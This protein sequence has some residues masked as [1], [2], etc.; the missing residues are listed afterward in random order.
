MTNLQ[1]RYDDEL[2]R[3]YCTRRNCNFSCEVASL[4]DG[5]AD[6]ILKYSFMKE[7]E[8]AFM[9][10]DTISNV[11]RGGHGEWCEM[12]KDNANEMDAHMCFIKNSVFRAAVVMQFIYNCTMSVFR[13]C[14]NRML[15]HFLIDPLGRIIPENGDY[16]H[17]IITNPRFHFARLLRSSLR[18]L[19]HEIQRIEFTR[20]CIH[21]F[22]QFLNLQLPQV[23]LTNKNL[24]QKVALEKRTDLEAIAKQH[25][26]LWKNYK[27]WHN[28]NLNF[29][30]TTE[31]LMACNL[32]KIIRM[33]DMHVVVLNNWTDFSVIPAPLH[34]RNFESL[35]I[36]L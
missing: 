31:R 36:K 2:K 35:F 23:G 34:P 18:I 8:V 26:F 10:Q 27:C 19:E 24:N 5:I 28:K 21:E 20:E 25:S 12:F 17:K 11:L 9:E 4:C 6:N 32:C 15:H 29:L 16:V 3:C 14:R 22:I 33:R 30:L 1:S 13:C 7:V